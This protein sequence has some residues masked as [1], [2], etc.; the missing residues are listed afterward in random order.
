MASGTTVANL[1]EYY[2]Q[3]GPAGFSKATVSPSMVMAWG[4]EHQLDAMQNV[5]DKHPQ[6]NIMSCSSDTIDP[7]NA[8]RKYWG[9]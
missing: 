4:E 2:G 6:D 1:F 7:E 5:L 3:E 9:G 8:C